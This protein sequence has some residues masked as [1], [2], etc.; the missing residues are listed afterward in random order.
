MAALGIDPLVIGIYA[1]NFFVVLFVLQ[2][3]VY[4]PVQETLEKRRRE[5]E[6]GLSA[7]ETA[8]Q[9]AAQQRADF[10]KELAKAREASQV[11]ARKA[12]EAT[13]K[14]RQEILV[15]AQRE[16]EDIKVQAR[17]EAEQERQQVAADL[18][19]QAAELAVQI[20]RKVIGESMDEKTQRNLV[21]KFLTDLGEAS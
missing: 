2:R 19:K 9:Q 4:K 11:E 15:A 3:L 6:S 14:M 10:E 16:A 8:Q 12:A 7:A 13:E 21:N 1:I 5:I 17:T 20:A 18:Q